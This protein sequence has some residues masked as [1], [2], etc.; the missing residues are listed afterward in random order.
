MRLSSH[1]AKGPG[2][3]LDRLSL[4]FTDGSGNG[5]YGLLEA[6]RGTLAGLVHS[7]LKQGGEVRDS[8]EML[9]AEG[10]ALGQKGE[11]GL[12]ALF[13]A[14]RACSKSRELLAPSSPTK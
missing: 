13:H 10:P 5:G 8:R 14:F 1:Q 4:Y 12:T 3:A 7:L 2:A 6:Q 11:L 9:E